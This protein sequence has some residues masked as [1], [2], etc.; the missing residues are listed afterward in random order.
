MSAAGGGPAQAGPQPVLEIYT[1]NGLEPYIMKPVGKGTE[2]FKSDT[3][4]VP[5]GKDRVKLH[6]E[7]IAYGAL[8]PV[9]GDADFEFLSEMPFDRSITMPHVNND[10]FQ[11]ITVFE[12]HKILRKLISTYAE[13]TDVVVQSKAQAYCEDIKRMTYTESNVFKPDAP[14][15]SAPRKRNVL[16]KISVSVANR[17]GRILKAAEDA[18]EKESNK[19]L[20]PD[21]IE[22]PSEF[23]AG[24]DAAATAEADRAAAEFGGGAAAQGGGSRRPSRKYNKSKR[25]L[26]RK[27][28]ATRRR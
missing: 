4:K 28:R 18:A 3:Y 20:K 16:R 22:I 15:W 24:D 23:E 10:N 2:M 14:Y 19:E 11:F 17:V 13:T 21:E 5:Q 27:F 7:L 26:R 12:N 25:V 6:S 9:L 8:Y 1:Q